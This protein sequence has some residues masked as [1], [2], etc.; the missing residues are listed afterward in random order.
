MFVVPTKKTARGIK[1]FAITTKLFFSVKTNW[2]LYGRKIGI[3]FIIKQ[4]RKTNNSKYYGY[5][6]IL[7]DRCPFKS[8][9]PKLLDRYAPDFSK[10]KYN[11]N[12]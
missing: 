1:T 5:C 4:C 3:F 8:E 11:T 10:K 7:N 6:D 2:E 9:A 12:K